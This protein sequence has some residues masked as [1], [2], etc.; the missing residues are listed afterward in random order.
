MLSL[1]L[2]SYSSLLPSL[3][4]SLSSE[5]FEGFFFFWPKEDFFE[6]VAALFITFLDAAFTSSLGGLTLITD[7]FAM[8][9]GGC[10]GV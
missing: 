3:D 6:V 4:S 8:G 5:E 1:S 7:G 10:S 2:L 9:S